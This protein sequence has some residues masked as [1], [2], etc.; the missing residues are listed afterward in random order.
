MTEQDHQKIHDGCL[1][2]SIMDT[3]AMFNNEGNQF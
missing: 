1:L 2:I 3:K